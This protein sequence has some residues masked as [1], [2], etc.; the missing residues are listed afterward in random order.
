MQSKRFAKYCSTSSFAKLILKED[1]CKVQYP[2]KRNTY[3]Y[4]IQRTPDI[5]ISEAWECCQGS[6][7]R[8]VFLDLKFV[9]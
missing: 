3:H 8:S 6:H 9:F 4:R 2:T 5:D 1:I 7:T